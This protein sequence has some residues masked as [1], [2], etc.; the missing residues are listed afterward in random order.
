MSKHYI[1]LVIEVESVDERNAAAVADQYLGALS[2]LITREVH[3]ATTGASV[4][5]AVG[6]LNDATGGI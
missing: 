3:T 1:A 6:R 2:T 5:E 4:E